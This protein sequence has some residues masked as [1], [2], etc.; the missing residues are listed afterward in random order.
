[1]AGFLDACIKASSILVPF[2]DTI[3]SGSIRPDEIKY[4][5]SLRGYIFNYVTT[6]KSTTWGSSEEAVFSIT[7]SD[8]TV[9]FK[10]ILH[11]LCTLLDAWYSLL[12]Q[13]IKFLLFN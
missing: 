1:M 7:V 3:I 8:N 13:E 11:N 6:W 9:S 4:I 12:Y 2:V 5:T 10:A